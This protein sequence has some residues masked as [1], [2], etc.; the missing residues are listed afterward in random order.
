M[1]TNELIE[2]LEEILRCDRIDVIKEI[3]ADVLGVEVGEY[4]NEESL[5]EGSVYDSYEE[6]YNQKDLFTYLD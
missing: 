2:A 3:A 1:S 6:E 4:T 5:K